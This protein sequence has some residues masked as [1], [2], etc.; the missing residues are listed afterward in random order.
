[1]ADVPVVPGVETKEY[2]LYF[3]SVLGGDDK[4]IKAKL[5]KWTDQDDKIIKLTITKNTFK[6]LEIF[7]ATYVE[8]EDCPDSDKICTELHLK[9]IMG[10]TTPVGTSFILHK[11]CPFVKNSRVPVHVVIYNDQEIQNEMH[12]KDFCDNCY[13]DPTIPD[14]KDGNV[15]I[16]I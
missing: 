3:E 2:V 10:K 11:L 7:M 6:N 14:S 16:G 15:L 1:M 4:I 9:A 12:R 13:D 8:E 5:E